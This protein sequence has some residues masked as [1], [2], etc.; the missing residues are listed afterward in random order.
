MRRAGI[1]GTSRSGAPKL[2][3]GKAN[4]MH[5]GNLGPPAA[6]GPAT[7]AG[8]RRLGITGRASCRA[9]ACNAGGTFGGNWIFSGGYMALNFSGAVLCGK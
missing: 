5:W 4:D 8:G 3:G 7:R 6:R 9:R 1:N 2:E